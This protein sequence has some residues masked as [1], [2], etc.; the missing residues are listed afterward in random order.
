MQSKEEWLEYFGAFVSTKEEAE[1]L[2]KKAIEDKERGEQWN[3]ETS[4][5]DINRCNAL[6]QI[7]AAI[8]PMA[9]EELISIQKERRIVYGEFIVVLGYVLDED[10]NWWDSVDL[11]EKDVEVLYRLATGSTEYRNGSFYK[12]LMEGRE[13]LDEDYTSFVASVAR[14]LVFPY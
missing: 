3:G 7:V 2:L 14:Q 10:P 5:S 12:E 8:R 9:W 1:K 13:T 6:Q 4:P 11:D